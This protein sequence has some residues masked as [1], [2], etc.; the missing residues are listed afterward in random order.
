MSAPPK[1]TVSRGPAFSVV[2]IVPLVALAVGGWMILREFRHRGPEIAIEFADSSGIEPD[3]TTLEYKG[4]DVGTVQSVELNPDLGGVTVRVRLTRSAAPLAVEGSR[5]WIVHPEIGF[6]GIRGID[7]LLTGA[8]LNV[9]PGRGAPA[10]HFRG[11]DKIPPAENVNEGRA[12][13][14]QG[15]KLGSLS[16]GA[17]VFYREMKVGVVET[18]RLADDAASVLIRIRIDTPYA[19]LVRTD[20]RFWNTGGA[21]FKL[22]LLGAELKSTSLESL[23]SGGVA[24][25]TPE[26]KD[27]LA[28]EAPDGAMFPLHNEADKD[29]LKWQPHIPITPPEEGAEPTPHANAL[30]PVVQREP[31]GH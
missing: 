6:S 18:S 26:G 23:F 7:T 30:A 1:P 24:F 9:R 16:P 21:T 25:A 14:L 22:S 31:A 13:L 11:L 10:T 20:T 17:P 27:G 12:F 19:A 5:F 4:V 29:W 8:R 28:P 15:D 2:W 3:K